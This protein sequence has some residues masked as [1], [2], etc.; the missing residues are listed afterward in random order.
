M[1]GMEASFSKVR[2]FRGDERFM[3]SDMGRLGRGGKGEPC[4]RSR[5]PLRGA[6]GRPVEG[7]PRP[8]LTLTRQRPSHTSTSIHQCCLLLSAWTA[9]R[10]GRALGAPMETGFA[11]GAG[12]GQ[13]PT[14]RNRIRMAA[15]TGNKLEDRLERANAAK[16]ALLERFKKRPAEMIRR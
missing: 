2:R 11:Q 4:L 10:A 3:A 13:S 1:R 5:S 16:Q 15:F 7:L 14:E 8:A 12:Q 9:D 6:Q